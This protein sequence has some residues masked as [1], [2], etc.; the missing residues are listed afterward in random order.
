[1][2]KKLGIAFVS[3]GDVESNP[4]IELIRVLVEEGRKNKIDCLLAAG[5]GSVIDTAKAVAMGVPNNCQ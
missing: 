1:M 3:N 4:K 2:C 5:G